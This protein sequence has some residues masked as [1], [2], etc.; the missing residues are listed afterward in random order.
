MGK[1]SQSLNLIY[2]DCLDKITQ[3]I[4]KILEFINEDE[5]V[6]KF[7]ISIDV[8]QYENIWYFLQIIEW[9]ALFK[10]EFVIFQEI[11]MKMHEIKQMQRPFRD[12]SIVLRFGGGF[13]VTNS[14]I[15]NLQTNTKFSYFPGFI[16]IQRLSMQTLQLDIDFDSIVQNTFGDY[17]SCECEMNDEVKLPDVS[18]DWLDKQIYISKNTNCESFILSGWLKI[19]DIISSTGDFTY[20]FIMLSANFENQFSNQ[21]L[22]PFQMSYQISSGVKKLLFSTYSQTFPDVTIDF[23]DDAFIIKKEFIITNSIL[24]WH[25]I[26][27]NLQDDLL[28]V[29]IK[30][31]EGNAI[32]E[33]NDQSNVHQFHCIQSKLQYGNLLQSAGSYVIVDVKNLVFMNCNES[34]QQQTVT[35]VVKT[36]MDLLCTI[37]YLV[38]SN[39]KEYI[40]KNIRFVSAHIIQ[41]M[42]ILAKF[43]LIQNYN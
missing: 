10:F 40:Y 8:L 12:T 31:Y 39:H 27:V 23:V 25:N 26:Y 14:N 15:P 42:N 4:K 29:V 33:Y 22:S 21:N 24:I 6:F 17:G 36:V 38:H 5:E 41:S 2:Y 32:Y 13:I 1:S 35:L 3:S 37:V 30:F 18:L 11:T 7:E 43:M 34:F 19:N 9:P 16:M 28:T 20:K